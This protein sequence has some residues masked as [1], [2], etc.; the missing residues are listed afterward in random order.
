M[1]E[2]VN[3]YGFKREDGSVGA[4]PEGIATMVGEIHKNRICEGK[5]RDPRLVLEVT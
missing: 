3:G 4:E 2:A 1:I 5:M